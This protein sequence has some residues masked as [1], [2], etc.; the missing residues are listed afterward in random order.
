MIRSTRG[1]LAGATLLVLA[2]A[3]SPALAF[4]AGAEGGGSSGGGSNYSA[5]AATST[6]SATPT[7]V[8]IQAILARLKQHLHDRNTAAQLQ[9]DIDEQT[10]ERGYLRQWQDENGVKGAASLDK[11]GIVPEQDGGLDGLPVTSW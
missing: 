4:N 6:K 7:M 1:R 8:D 3:S 11:Y 2:L 9:A 5:P 10:I